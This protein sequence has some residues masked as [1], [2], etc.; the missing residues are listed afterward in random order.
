MKV[1]NNEDE[2]VLDI[3]EESS[4]DKLED[5]EKDYSNQAAIQEQLFSAY[6]EVSKA[7]ED[8]SD[9]TDM[10]EDCWD[11]YN[12]KMTANQ[13]YSG[14]SQVFLPLVKDAVNAKATRYIN[15]LF[16]KSG[17]YC[18]VIS[19]D[20]RVPYDL[21]ALLEYYVRTTCLR[22]N[23]VPALIRQGENG[24]QYSLYISWE[25]QVRNIV[26][27]KKVIDEGETIDG[28]DEYDDVEYE[29]DRQGGP[30]VT[31]LD[32][33][34]L[35]LLPTSIDSVEDAETVAI[36]RRWSKA[37][38]RSLVKMGILEK[39]PV[40]L[41]LENM[42]AKPSPNMPDTIKDAATNAGVSTDSKGNKQAIIFEVWKTL[43][44]GREHR[45]MVSYF[46][47]QNNIL[48]C[49]RNPYWND[50]V[51]VITQPVE[52]QADTIWGKPPVD[53]VRQ[54]A[55][56]AND[57]V[58]MG[59][60]S[61]Q[62]SLMP[63]V[64][65]DPEKNPRVGS[66]ILNMAAIWETSPNDTKFV[67]MPALWKDAFQMVNACKEQIQQSLGVN[68]A[69][70]PMGNASKKPSQA[71][72]A[73][74]QQV[75][76]ESTADQ[77][78]IIQEGVLNKL[79]RWFYDL[80]YQFRTKSV[81][82]KKFG[83]IGMLADMQQVEPFQ[84][85]QRLTFNWYGMESSKAAQEIQGMI[86]WA[87]VLRGMP[88]QVLNGRTVDLGPVLEYVSEVT[89]G[90]RVAPKVLIDER[91]K[92]NVD[93]MMENQLMDNLFPVQVHE[94]DN[95]VEHIKVHQ[96]HFVQ[97]GMDAGDP[98]HLKRGHLLEHIKQLKE[99]ASKAQGAQQ[100]QPQQ[101]QPQGAPGQPQPGASA[102]TP[103][104]P[105]GP[106]GTIH[107]DSMRDPNAMPR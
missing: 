12:C 54:V 102:Q 59:F 32:P 30:S 26:S 69:M 1:E 92:F 15:T 22:T 95:D 77:I 11:V 48:G 83:Q 100:P 2:E 74:E 35:V 52:K 47:G 82:I 7:F 17:R 72:V 5:R 96:Q 98:D 44:I 46:A 50:R 84:E 73:Q 36:I 62:Y 65:T 104:G 55:Y 91:H 60:D 29:E 71:Q 106:P 16:P 99:K 78:T 49:K 21:I 51:P 10:V 58:N 107:P 19:D 63:I 68:P 20:G 89:F 70:I 9:Q 67:N 45:L 37:K 64:L 6:S 81:S 90:P 3:E 97:T 33:R 87:N 61:A 25:E 34:N 79:L 75:A 85:R 41:L 18:D 4:E 24:G 56:S 28:V 43:K 27:K 53:A 40:D 86:S 14:T 76:L 93:P 101:G 31:V 88:P 8:K 38:L 42:N 57:A 66:M 103:T 13:A 80:D 105:Q 23:I 94:G 39:K